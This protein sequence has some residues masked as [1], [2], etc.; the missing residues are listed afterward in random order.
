MRHAITVQKF[1]VRLRPV[2]LD[3]AAFI[4][5]LRNSPHAIKFIGD[6]AQTVTAQKKWLEDHF[7]HPHDYNF[8]IELVQRPQAVGML[9]IYNIQGDRGEWGRWVI[10]PGILAGP[11]SAWLVLHVCY[12]V[13]HLRIVCGLI[14]ESNSEVLSF[15]RRAGYI[16]KGPQPARRLIGGESIGMVEVVTTRADWPKVS[17]TLETYAVAA[18]KFLGG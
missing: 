6:S 16:D 17:K 18:Q 12:E 11:A 3:D 13:L 4:V 14:V 10:Q 2:R 1:G 5:Q 7:E 8:I 15:H 9:G